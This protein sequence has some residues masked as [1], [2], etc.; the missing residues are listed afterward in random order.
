MSCIKWQSYSS[1]EL[2]GNTGGIPA[3]SRQ[4]QKGKTV[5]VAFSDEVQHIGHSSTLTNHTACTI[6]P[7]F[8]RSLWLD[9]V[10]PL[11]MDRET[12]A[13]EKCLQVL[14][15]VLLN[16]IVPYSRW[17]SLLQVIRK[18][19]LSRQCFGRMLRDRSFCVQKTHRSSF[20]A[21]SYMRMIFYPAERVLIS[22]S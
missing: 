3:E 5:G 6:Y 11:V 21:C 14:E 16:N 19:L 17:V 13:Q 4:V 15:E 20:L 8:F 18:I 7:V 2:I 10:L 12:T 22:V 1:M 9:G